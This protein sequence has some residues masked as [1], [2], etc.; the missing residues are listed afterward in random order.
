MNCHIRHS[1][2]LCCFT[3]T[4]IQLESGRKDNDSSRQLALNDDIPQL[5]LN[6]ISSWN[7]LCWGLARDKY[8]TLGTVGPTYLKKVHLVG[9][10]P[11][12]CLYS[13]LYKAE[14]LFPC[15]KKYRECQV[16]VRSLATSST[17][18]IRLLWHWIHW[19]FTTFNMFSSLW[20]AFIHL[21]LC[22]IWF[23]RCISMLLITHSKQKTLTYSYWVCS[24]F[25]ANSRMFVTSFPR[26]SHK[27]QFYRNSLPQN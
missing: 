13:I 11:S 17:D 9:L 26:S 10:N 3:S 21:K 15:W 20:E 6:I 7:Q 16:S 2:I 1:S 14:T 25:A 18:D 8:C 19:M 27:L 22:V 23:C 5:R 4:H 24:K 12:F